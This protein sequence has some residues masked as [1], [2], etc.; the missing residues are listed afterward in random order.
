[1]VDPLEV[2]EKHG[3]D[4]LRFSLCKLTIGVNDLK[5][6]EQEIIQSKYFINKFGTLPSLCFSIWRKTILQ[7]DDD[8]KHNKLDIFSKRII[9]ELRETIYAYNKNLDEYR[10]FEIAKLL[11][12]F[13]WGKFCD[14]YI[15][16]S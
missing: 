6:P 4:A 9:H 16:I 5:L 14:E 1:M 12:N 11:Y 2:I 3:T 8:P 10:F 13:I 15:E 7:N